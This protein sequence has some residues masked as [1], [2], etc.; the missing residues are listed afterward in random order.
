MKEGKIASFSS[1]HLIMT[2]FPSHTLIDEKKDLRELLPSFYRKITYVSFTFQ[3][4]KF[5]YTSNTQQNRSTK[6][7]M[8]K[9]YSVSF[10]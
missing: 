4:F 6:K 7:M 10:V 9:V 2:S 1:L 8:K 3:N 5:N